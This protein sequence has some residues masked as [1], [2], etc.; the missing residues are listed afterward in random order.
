MWRCGSCL[1]GHHATDD[2]R[3]VC[4]CHGDGPMSSDDELSAFIFLT[5]M[6]GLAV[7]T[8]H[9]SNAARS[10]GDVEKIIVEPLCELAKRRHPDSLSPG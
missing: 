8:E 6:E 4:G 10:G 2:G 9:L 3:C 5:A 7:A 1:I